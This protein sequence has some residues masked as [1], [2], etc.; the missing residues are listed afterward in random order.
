[1]AIILKANKVNLFVSFVLFVFWYHT[2][3]VLDTPRIYL[4]EADFVA[5][6][7]GKYRRQTKKMS[8]PLQVNSIRSLRALPTRKLSAHLAFYEQNIR[9]FASSIF[10]TSRSIGHV[11]LSSEGAAARRS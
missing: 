2:P 10:D 5:D 4:A 11:F 9:I 7:V 8:S 1:M 6:S 3:N